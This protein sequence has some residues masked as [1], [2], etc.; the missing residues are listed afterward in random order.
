MLAAIILEAA[1][2]ASAPE[3]KDGI[4][5]EVNSNNL[6]SGYYKEYYAGGKSVECEGRVKNG[7]REDQ[8]T[9]YYG[10]NNLKSV[11]EFEQGIKV[12]VLQSWYENGDRE[13]LFD[14]D[15][16]I[17]TTWYASGKLKSVTHYFGNMKQGSSME[18]YENGKVKSEYNYYQ[19][20][21][22]GICKEYYTNGHVSLI[23]VYQD[24]K[25][26]GFWQGF[27]SDGK[28]QYQGRY[29]DDIKTGRWIVR[30]ENGKLKK[31]QY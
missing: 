24:G 7:L 30:D 25:R 21:E 14:E 5:Y 28:L 20:H 2:P 23:A 1:A 22:H 6:Y 3:L 16:L 4:F 15:S 29:S 11:I 12:K 17:Y 31:E 8:W 27:K 13:S 26:N 19:H 18:W 10:N 9:Y